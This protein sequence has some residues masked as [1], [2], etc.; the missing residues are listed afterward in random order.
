MKIKL[1]TFINVAGDWLQPES[2]ELYKLIDAKVISSK[3][4]FIF[5]IES[6]DG[7][8]EHPMVDETV[9]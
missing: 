5:V 6:V 1:S 8:S 4:D 9:G 7:S 2:D 3:E